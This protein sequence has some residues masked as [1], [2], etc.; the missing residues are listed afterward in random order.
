MSYKLTAKVWT[1]NSW[2]VL[3][4]G[5]DALSRVVNAAIG[6]K[7]LYSVMK[8][9][10][11]RTMQQTAEKNGIPWRQRVAELSKNQEVGIVSPPCILM[12]SIHTIRWTF[13]AV[14]VPHN[15]SM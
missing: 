9:M 5:D 8:V 11:K 3:D 6:F 13:T 12:T 15:P 1:S 10:A 2:H 4:A 7:P 14:L